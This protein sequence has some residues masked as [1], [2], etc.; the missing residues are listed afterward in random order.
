[1]ASDAVAR[2]VTPD[3]KHL[4]FYP[5]YV[6]HDVHPGYVSSQWA[7]EMNC[8]RKRCFIIMLMRR[9]VWQS[10]VAAGWR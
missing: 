9:R 8:R 6:V 1:M 10:T 3:A 7:R 5:A 2:S 4:R